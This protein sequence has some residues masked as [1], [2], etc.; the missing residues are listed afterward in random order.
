MVVVFF[1][2]FGA[3]NKG[4]VLSSAVTVWVTFV[5]VLLSPGKVILTV[6]APVIWP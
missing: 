2:P 3:N 4:Y 6:V 1:Y 5:S